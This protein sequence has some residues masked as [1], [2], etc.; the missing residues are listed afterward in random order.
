MFQDR[1]WREGVPFPTKVQ[2]KRKPVHPTVLR[3]KR[4]V[5]RS[6][7]GGIDSL[8]RAE[9]LSHS[10][11]PG[12]YTEAQRSEGPAVRGA[13]GACSGVLAVS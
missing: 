12:G 10:H 9:P 4:N 8:L 2:G 13:P 3:N 6:W 11:L 7:D 1:I 5:T